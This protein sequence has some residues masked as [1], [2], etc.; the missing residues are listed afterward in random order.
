MSKSLFAR[1][2][3]KFEPEPEIDRREFLRI[4]LAAGAGLLISGNETLWGKESKGEWGSRR[5]VIIGAGFAGLA[6]AHEFV[7]AGCD[8]TLLEA[9]SRAGGRVITL[10]NLVKGKH[11]EGGAEFIGSNHPAWLAYAKHFGLKLLEDS[12]DVDAD[13]ALFFDGHLLDE[14]RDE[15][16]V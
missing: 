12:G 13:P 7:T 11:I 2:A 3:Q 6:C 4:T 16:L 14:Q 8:V 9:R 5:F 10:H 15:S 1:L